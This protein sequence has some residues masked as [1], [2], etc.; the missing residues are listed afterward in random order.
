VE[1]IMVAHK[2]PGPIIQIKDGHGAYYDSRFETRSFLPGVLIEKIKQAQ[3]ENAKKSLAEKLARIA[4]QRVVASAKGPCAFINPS[5]KRT[6]SASS[7][8]FTRLRNRHGSATITSPQKKAAKR[9]WINGPVFRAIEQKIIITG[10]TIRAIRPLEADIKG[11]NF[12]TIKQVAE[13]LR[14]IPPD[15]LIHTHSF[16]LSPKPSPK[17]ETTAGEGGSGEVVFFPVSTAQTQNNFDNR[18]MHE[19]AHNYHAKFWAGPDGL[20]KWQ[21]A[22][23]LDN[24]LPSLYCREGAGEDFCE[25]LILY[26]TT[27]GAECEVTC[28]KIYPHRWAK[29]AEYLSR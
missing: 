20:T 2:N 17:G 14:T 26:N 7:E 3:A 19:C 24:R 13:A 10:H 28:S 25:F 5:N 21:D 4:R 27:D 29:V 16:A 12:P 22:A 23:D 1:K 6:V 8:A 18:M 15:Q 11:K 9:W